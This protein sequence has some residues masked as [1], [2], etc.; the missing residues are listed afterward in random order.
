MGFGLYLDH[1]MQDSVAVVIEDNL[2]VYE[3]TGEIEF[4]LDG[5]KDFHD[6]WDLDGEDYMPE[7]APSDE[8]FW[9]VDANGD[10]IPQDV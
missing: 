5:A 6:T 7:E 10:L 2:W 3:T 9:D 4:G 8:G 1:S